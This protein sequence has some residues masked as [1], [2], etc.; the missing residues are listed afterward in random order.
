MRKLS[1]ARALEEAVDANEQSHMGSAHGGMSHAVYKQT[2]ASAAR[3]A[4]LMVMANSAHT[5][6]QSV[7]TLHR[8]IRSVVSY[9]RG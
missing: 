9:I 1:Q 7:A 6:A 3:A 2:D 8:V 4:D 5:A